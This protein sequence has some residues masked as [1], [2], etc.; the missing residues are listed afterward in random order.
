M[1]A[2]SCVE[3]VLGECATEGVDDVKVAAPEGPAHVAVEG[4]DPQGL[5]KVRRRKSLDREPRGVV[6]ASAQH[7]HIV[8]GPHQFAGDVPG[9][10]LTTPTRCLEVF[11]D[12][13][14]THAVATRSQGSVELAGS[15]TVDPGAAERRQAKRSDMRK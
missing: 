14:Y 1:T 12:Q 15:A 6:S 11:H 10:P 4:A 8:A 7:M 13:G 2:A 3:D 5:P 9:N